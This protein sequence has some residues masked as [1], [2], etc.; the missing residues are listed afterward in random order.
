MQKVIMAII[1]LL[2]LSA[3][4]AAM[5]E[6]VTKDASVCKIAIEIGTFFCYHGLSEAIKRL[7][8]DSHAIIGR[9]SG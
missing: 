1:S 2:T 4:A 8:D 7:S 5:R 6:N 9:S 3:S